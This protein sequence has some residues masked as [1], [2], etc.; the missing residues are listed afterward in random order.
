ME[1]QNMAFV[2]KGGAETK[3]KIRFIYVGFNCKTKKVGNKW[4]EHCAIKRGGG[5]GLRRQMANV[6]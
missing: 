1:I 6:I 4:R 5:R 2:V 3:C